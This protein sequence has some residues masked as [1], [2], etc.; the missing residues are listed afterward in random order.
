MLI[1]IDRQQAGELK[2]FCGH[3]GTFLTASGVSRSAKGWLW[4]K[5]CIILQLKVL[6]IVNQRNKCNIHNN[7]TLPQ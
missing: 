1:C 2:I 4:M 7:T 5:Y 6:V 3:F